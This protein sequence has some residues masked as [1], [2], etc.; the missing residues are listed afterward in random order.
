MIAYRSFIPLWVFLA[1]TVGAAQAVTV[2]QIPSPRPAGWVVDL[3][4]TLPSQTV[5]DLNR[6]G[7]D[8]KARTGA[9]L[10]VVVIPTTGGA[11]HRD[12]ATRLF[13]LWGIGERGKDNGVLVFAALDDRAAEIILGNGVD[14]D[15]RVR[16][17]EA[18]MQEVM[19]PRFREG[20]AAGALWHGARACADRILGAAV[21][22]TEA[23]PQ[24]ATA[25]Q[26]VPVSAPPQSLHQPGNGRRSRDM[27]DLLAVLLPLGAAGG[28]G[29]GLWAAFRPPRCPRCREK[30]AKMDEVADDAYL[31]PAEQLEERI[32]S[33][34]HQIW[35]CPACGERTKRRSVRLFSGYADCPQCSVRALR[36]TT[37]TLQMATYTHG[38]LVRIDEECAN[39]SH[40]NSFTRS[41]PQRRRSSGSRSSGFGGGRS[42]GRGASGRW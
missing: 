20:D 3:T 35:T 29:F 10:A 11:E 38:G 1:L 19:V 25:P 7:D 6:L 28:V 33:V 17:S 30:M 13:N 18:I 12:F 26:P 31:Q 22:Q 27:G 24:P 9:E 42:S 21:P 41:T 16:A 32:G 14:D 40:R 39:C 34:D 23:T 2:E 5:A 8:V 36:S 37:T 15:A 4:G